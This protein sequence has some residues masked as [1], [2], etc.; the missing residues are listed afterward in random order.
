M[1]LTVTPLPMSTFWTSCAGVWAV[2][3]VSCEKPVVAGKMVASNRKIF[4]MP[5]PNS[6]GKNW[7]LEKVLKN[8][9]KS[10]KKKVVIKP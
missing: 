9:N 10:T 4:F 5:L 3:T 2:L 6:M 7:F 1:L 8:K